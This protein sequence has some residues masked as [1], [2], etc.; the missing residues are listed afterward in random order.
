MGV[1]VVII[2]NKANSVLN[3]TCQLELSLEKIHQRQDYEEVVNDSD[4][5]MYIFMHFQGGLGGFL[6]SCY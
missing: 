3:W 4:M 2:K 1:G 5:V 6:R